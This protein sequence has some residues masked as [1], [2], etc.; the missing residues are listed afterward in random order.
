MKLIFARTVVSQYI[1]TTVDY[2]FKGEPLVAWKLDNLPK[3]Q[4]F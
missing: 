4:N 2:I 1:P 3:S